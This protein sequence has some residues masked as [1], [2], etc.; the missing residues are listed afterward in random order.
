MAASYEQSCR[1]RV[2]SHLAAVLLLLLF[3][4][5]CRRFGDWCKRRWCNF[6]NFRKKE[7]SP[8]PPPKIQEP[9]KRAR[10]HTHTHTHARTH[11]H[12][13]KHIYTHRFTMW[14]EHFLCIF[15]KDNC[16]W[17]AQKFTA[18][19]HNLLLFFFFFAFYDPYISTYCIRIER[20]IKAL[21]NLTRER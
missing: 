21:P 4:L 7:V 18:A 3:V 20:L 15:F 14:K 17:I 12:T 8:L 6:S 10:T 2:T 9:R 19:I 13:N 16:L 5:N 1:I 11:T